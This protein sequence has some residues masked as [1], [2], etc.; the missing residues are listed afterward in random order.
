MTKRI[1]CPVARPTRAQIKR[2]AAATDDER[3]RWWLG[4][5]EMLDGA[6]DGATRRSWRTFRARR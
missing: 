2:F 6:V 4:M 3:F 5:L 1:E